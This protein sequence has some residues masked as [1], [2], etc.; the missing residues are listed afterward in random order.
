MVQVKEL[1]HLFDTPTQLVGTPEDLEALV[2]DLALAVPL[3]TEAGRSEALALWRAL[4]VLCPEAQRQ[5]FLR[6]RNL[7]AITDLEIAEQLKIPERYV[8]HLF[9]PNFRRHVGVGLD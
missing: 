4:G 6:K 1:M 7:G 9:R 3:S 2:S 5:E 8:P